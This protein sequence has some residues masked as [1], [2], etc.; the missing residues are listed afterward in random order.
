MQLPL[1]RQS[2][3][4]PRRGVLGLT[5]MT[6]CT[7]VLARVVLERLLS[8]RACLWCMVM[9]VP[10]AYGNLPYGGTSECERGF[11]WET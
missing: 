1:A 11:L 3:G 4:Y 6:M 5:D 10:S 2:C 8:R 9:V 7:Q